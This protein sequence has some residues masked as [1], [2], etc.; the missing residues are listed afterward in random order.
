M[1]GFVAALN[2]GAFSRT[3]VADFLL[4]SAE[5]LANQ[6]AQNQAAIGQMYVTLL[7]RGATLTEYN[8]SLAELNSGVVLPSL[9]DAILNSAEYKARN[10]PF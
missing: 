9:V 5:Y 6:I 1:Q 4:T 10:L 2:S 8:Q 7:R 3:Q